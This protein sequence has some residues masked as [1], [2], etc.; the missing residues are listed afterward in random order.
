MKFRLKVKEVEAV[1]WNK[2]GDVQ[3]VQERRPYAYYQLSTGKE[4]RIPILIGNSMDALLEQMREAIKKD[5]KGSFVVTDHEGNALEPLLLRSRDGEVP[6]M[7][8][9]LYRWIV[10]VFLL[11]KLFLVN[12]NTADGMVEVHPGDWIIKDPDNK[13]GVMSDSSFTAAFE[14]VQ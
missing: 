8:E 6:F 11:P 13:L 2:P 10:E 14:P 4:N 7:D 9:A 5:S 12:T 1:Q 3:I